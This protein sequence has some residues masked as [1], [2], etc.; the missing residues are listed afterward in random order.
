MSE[1]II[2]NKV[3]ESGLQEINLE[4]YYPA[5]ETLIFDLKDFLFMGLILKEK[6]FR[7]ALKKLDFSIYQNKLVA[8][9][10]TAD[11]IIP[12][13]A[14][15]LV[16]SLLQPVAKEMV[17]GDDT[18]LHKTLFLRNINTINLEEYRDRR[19][20]IKGC[21]D[22]ETGPFAYFEITKL[23]RPLAKSI[24]Y[25]EPCSTV[26]VFKKTAGPTV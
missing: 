12:V 4:E 19:V 25:G 26:P 3:A 20:V 8:V 6:D 13:W 24:M 21:G 14:F 16:A 15:M 10:C 18:F 9:T 1:D 22:L 17:L 23:L 5:G 7:E 2:V 11:A